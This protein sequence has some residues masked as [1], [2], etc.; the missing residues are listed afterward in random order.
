M[1][2]QVTK[3]V[4]ILSGES[5]N[6]DIFLWVVR[7]TSLANTIKVSGGKRGRV[8]VLSRAGPLEVST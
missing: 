8:F 1:F 3:A 7:G 2:F 4:W 6:F 5:S